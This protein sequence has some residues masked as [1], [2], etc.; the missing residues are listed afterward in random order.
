MKYDVI[1]IGDASEDIFVSPRDLKIVN[2]S[3]FVTGRGASF[4]LGEK[5]LLD[6]VEYEVGGSACNNAVAF[7]RQGFK[8][9]CI[10]AIGKDTPGQKIKERLAEEDVNCRYVQERKDGKSNF[11]VIFNIGDERTIFVYHGL[12]DY[13]CLKPSSNLAAK[14]VFIA[15]LGE[16]DE[17]VIQG[18]IT[19]AA[20]KN[21]KIAWNP[22]GVQIKKTAT[23]YRKLLQC[24]E[25]LFVNREEG[26][27]FVNFPILPQPKEIL[28]ALQGYG[29]KKVVLTD[30]KKGAYVYDRN[31]YFHAD[32]LSQERV[33]A[34]GAGDSFSTGFT[35]R[36]ML[37]DEDGDDK[38][39]EA[40]KWGIANST[41][42]VGVIGAQRGLLSQKQILDRL[43]ER[44]INIEEI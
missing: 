23:H 42:V 20:E 31:K 29:V 4:E 14:W 11:S 17:E 5:I 33:D 36:M 22:G 41:S 40:L 21:T 19:L 34:T 13:S 16:G 18:V 44:R 2:D 35:G 12:D 30:G 8:T 26:I 37:P 32:A 7:A 10:I 3:R 39:I 28:K 9:S 1:T 6:D 15:P 43:D 27:K 25:I 24:T 38:T